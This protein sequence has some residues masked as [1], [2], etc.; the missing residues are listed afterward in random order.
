LLAVSAY[1]FPNCSCSM[2]QGKAIGNPV[3][4]GIY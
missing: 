3:Q 1:L 4:I 2:K